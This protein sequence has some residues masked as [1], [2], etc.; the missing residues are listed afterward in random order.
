MRVGALERTT[1]SA[2]YLILGATIAIDGT[3]IVNSLRRQAFESRQ[4]GQYQLTERI[5]SGGMG[6]VWKA[7]HRMLA[8]PAAIKLIRPDMLGAQDTAEA[9]MILRRFERE[10]QATAALSSPHSIILYD[11]GL[12]DDGTF[13]SVM[14]FLEGLDLESL[15]RR[16]GPLTPARTVSMLNQTCQSLID[17][18]N[19]GLIHRDIKPA[20]LFASRLGHVYDFVKVLDFGLVKSQAKADEAETRLTQ[21]ITGTPA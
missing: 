10:A 21:G 5:G 8:R 18:H 1:E 16:F 13:Y 6:E 9:Q 3:H 19:N 11:F 15:V 2:I 4:L 17:A 7:S 14:E 20:N 12:T